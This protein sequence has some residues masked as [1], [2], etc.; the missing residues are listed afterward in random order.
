MESNA[1][2]IAV[3]PNKIRIRVGDI[4]NFNDNGEKFYISKS[5]DSDGGYGYTS[6]NKFK[7][8][9][10][11]DLTQFNLNRRNLRFICEIIQILPPK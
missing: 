11:F 8:W 5:S 4:K 7:Y 10:T 1:E 2:V 9:Q 6:D 3:M